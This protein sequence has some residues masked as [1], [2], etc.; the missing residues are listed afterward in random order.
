[1]KHSACVPLLVALVACGRAAPRLTLLEG[2]AMGTTF[3]VQVVDLPAALDARALRARVDE[4]LA[5]IDRTMSTWDPASELS[6]FNASDS[7]DWFEVSSGTLTVVAEAQRI[8]R[9]TGGAFDVTIGPLVELWGF[10]PPEPRGRP[11]PEALAGVRGAVGFEKLELR[12]TPP[13]LRKRD[14]ALRVDLSAIAKGFA[15]DE[16]V[17][18]LEAQGACDFLVEVGGELGARGRNPAGAP[19]HVAVE[20]PPPAQGVAPCRVALV[21]CAVA[22]SGDYARFF[23]QDGVRYTHVIDPRSGLP[24]QTGVASATVLSASAMEADALATALMVLSPDEGLRLAAREAL[25]VRLLVRV[26]GGFDERRSLSFPAR[27]P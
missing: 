5:G 7:L 11:T 14:P 23:E 1:M 22:T 12:A 13:A 15:V 3:C 18:L 9:L 4:V 24:V 2:A 10:G 20:H 16:V 21:D 17:R 6:R 26:E 19:W 27:E 8:G 25:A